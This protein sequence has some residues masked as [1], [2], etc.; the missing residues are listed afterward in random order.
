MTS[1]SVERG[2]IESGD[3]VATLEETQRNHDRKP[4]GGEKGSVE[5]TFNRININ[6]K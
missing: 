5:K 6:E 2:H 3:R 4:N 1:K